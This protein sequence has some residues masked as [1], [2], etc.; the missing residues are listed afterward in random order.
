MFLLAYIWGNS[1]I[2][3]KIGLKSFTTD[4][5]GAVRILLASLVQ[6]PISLRQ[7]KNLQRKDVKRLL[8]AGFIGSFFWGITAFIKNRNT[9]RQ[10][11]HRH[12]QVIAER[13]L[14]QL[15]VKTNTAS[16]VRD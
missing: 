13:A 4:R 7:L 14:R 11:A 5:A 2:L 9:Y 1:F 12:A 8:A 16:S 10:L 6:L 15:S 3:M